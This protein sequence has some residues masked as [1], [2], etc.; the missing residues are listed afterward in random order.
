MVMKIGNFFGL[1]ICLLLVLGMI[2][3]VSALTGSIGNA[4]MI[5]RDVETGDVIK[6]TILVKNVNNIPV[7]IELFASGDLEDSVKIIDN[8][9]RLDAGEEK[10][11]AIEIEVKKSGTTET[12][13][14]IKFSPIDGGNG[15]GLSSTIIIIAEKGPGFIE[16]LFGDDDSSDDGSDDGVGDDSNMGNDEVS[17]GSNMLKIGLSATAFIFLVF[18]ILLY[19]AAKKKREIE[20]HEK[21]D[22]KIKPKKSSSKKWTKK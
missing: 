12:K 11:A 4:R 9:F 5:L 6:K 10:K 18:V 19:F 13:I 2:G 7:D 17:S 1:L 15:V 22:L 8:N 16:G 14:N 3:Q 21:K 20:S